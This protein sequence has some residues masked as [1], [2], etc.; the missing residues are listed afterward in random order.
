MDTYSFIL[1]VVTYMSAAVISVTLFARLG[2]GS[3]LGYLVA[4]IV[5]GP[6]GLRYINNAEDVL[7]FSELGVVLLL[8]LI[9][10][11]LDP[12]KLWSMRTPIVIA[13]GLQVL[14]TALILGAAMLLLGLPWQ[15]ALIAG[16]GLSLSSTAIAL[17]TLKER[18]LLQ[19]PF[20]KTGFSI[21]LLQDISVIP[22]LVL[23]PIVAIGTPDLS[24]DSAP[25]VTGL[26]VVA[27]FISIFV[28]GRYTLRHVFRFVAATHLPEVFTALSLLLVCGIGA[29]MHQIGVSMALGAFLGGVILADS[30]Y[31]HALESDI[32]PFK[33]LLLG[34]FFISV[35]MTIDFGLLFES[36]LVILAATVVLVCLKAAVL[37]V[38]AWL[39]RLDVS[40]RPLFAF[41]LCQ[42]GEFA[43]VL[44]GFAATTG[45]IDSALSD[46]LILIVAMSMVTTP[47]LLLLHDRC[48]E[49]LFAQAMDREMDDIQEENQVILVGFGRFGQVIGR[50]LL[51]N[52]IVPTVIEND[53]DHI[54]R[55]RRYGYKTYYGDIFRHDVLHSIGAHNASLIILTADGTEEI[56]LAV[57]LIQ[58][59]FPDLNIIARAHD[60]AHAMHLIA[61]QVSGVTRETFFSAVEMGKLTLQHLGFS[62]DRIEK[63]ATTY[64]RHDIEVLKRQMDSPGDEDTLVSIAK[65]A[66]QQLEQTLRADQMDSA[67]RKTGAN[68][69]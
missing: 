8:F 60:R 5:I 4:G 3:V 63:I 17:Q 67:E 39:F 27:V 16:L 42:S 2:L 37:Y 66:R 41:T 45:S 68:P 57:D 50:M 35:G 47:L 36:P 58:R 13:G 40:Q 1:S 19:S 56:N 54:E 30:E 25:A 44:F 69:D 7:H 59:E 49:P 9:G 51:A 34:L 32:Q 20:G 15:T 53:P 43:F 22:I 38:I 29:I 64:V 28:V 62:A 52:N 55:V 21:L 26:I 23:I 18:R 12:R 6:W 11:E 65:H 61:R 33:G 46:Q 10:L 31:R 24:G 14:L 48:I